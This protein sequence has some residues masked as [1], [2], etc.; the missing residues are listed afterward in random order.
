LNQRVYGG[1]GGIRTHGTVSRTLAFEASTFNR[2][3][4][5]PRSVTLFYQT[6]CCRGYGALRLGCMDNYQVRELDSP[7]GGEERLQQGTGLFREQTRGDFDLMIQLG[8]GEEFEAT[9]ER[10]AFGIVGSV[11]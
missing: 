11:N 1:E 3:V 6:G 2:S 4:T 8:S 9:A 5:S 7:A 10:S